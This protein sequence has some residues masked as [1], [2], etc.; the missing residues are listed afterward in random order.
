M[1]TSQKMSVGYTGG[2]AHLI[3]KNSVRGNGAK[4]KV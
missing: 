1:V 2:G 3:G 4:G